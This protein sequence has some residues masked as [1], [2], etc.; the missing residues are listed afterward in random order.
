MLLLSIKK[1]SCIKLLTLSISFV[2]FLKQLLQHFVADGGKRNLKTI[3]RLCSVF[4]VLN[5][6]GTVR[7]GFILRFPQPPQPTTGQR[8]K[9]IDLNFY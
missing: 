4:N 8:L 2:I 9:I 6:S 1:L 5:F 7:T 3:K